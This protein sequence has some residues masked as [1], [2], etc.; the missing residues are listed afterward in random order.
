V[1]IK[2]KQQLREAQ[3]FLRQQ[4]QSQTNIL[5][6]PQISGIRQ[7]KNKRKSVASSSN[8]SILLDDEETQELENHEEPEEPYDSILDVIQANNT[9]W[10][11]T[12]Y[13][14][15]RLIYLKTAIKTLMLT[16]I[17]ELN[18]SD[19]RREGARLSELY[20]SSTEWELISELVKILS[21]Y[22]I[23]TKVVC[24]SNYST[25]GLVYPTIY[26]LIKKSHEILNT[27]QNSEAKE[28]GEIILEDLETRWS[29]PND[30][31][32][33]ASFFDLRFKSLS[34][35]KRVIFL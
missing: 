7:K 22:E 35:Y 26:E 23:A 29:L 28:V 3:L 14:F 8:S 9:R 27:I 17:N 25:A 2:K 34:N 20:L 11:S 33:F 19:V 12:L 10:N 24:A 15:E 6:T 4:H 13:C 1:V 30:A 21:P 18:Y 31:L 5:G 32:V 16:L